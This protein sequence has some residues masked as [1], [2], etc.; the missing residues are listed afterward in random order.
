MDYKAI[1]ELIKTVSD[2]KLTLVEL[3]TEGIKIKLEKKQE[4]AVEKI[5]ETIKK[6]SVEEI[7][8]AAAELMTSEEKV[9]P[10]V[11]EV[12]KEGTIVTSPIVGTFYA[13]QGPDKESFVKVGSR[14][15]K[16][17]TLC[18]IE[19]MKLMNEIDS[20]VD[21]EVVEV[22]VENEQMVEYG[23]PLFRII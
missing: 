18:I 3:E 11:E 22:L 20:E 23:Q 17:D 21:G 19:A 12:K 7:P 8:Q 4:T 10:R 2:S 5:T 13:S 16:G 14:V 15:K 6:V 9:Q 1:Q